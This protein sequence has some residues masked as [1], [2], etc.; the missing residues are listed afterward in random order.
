MRLN[1]CR[2]LVLRF[3]HVHFK[4]AMKALKRVMLNV[5]VLSVRV[6]PI[7]F[8]VRNTFGAGSGPDKPG[9]T[10]WADVLEWG[11]ISLCTFGFF[12][13]LRHFVLETVALAFARRDLEREKL[14]LLLLR[15]E[16][17]LRE[18]APNSPRTGRS[19]THARNEAHKVHSAYANSLFTVLQR[20]PFKKES[21]DE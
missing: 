3:G 19:G 14:N 21:S 18:E 8:F 7:A 11:L 12:A 13:F 2:R 6:L 9:S 20:R 15:Q 17:L 16:S 10:L 5:S 4:V 1:L